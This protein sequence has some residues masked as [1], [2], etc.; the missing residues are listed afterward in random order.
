MRVSL[1]LLVLV[2]GLVQA[3]VYKT[4]TESGEVIYSDTPT[5]NAERMRLPE[6]PTYTPPPLPKSMASPAKQPVKKSLYNSMVISEPE[7]D[8]T[9]RD[10]QGLVQVSIEL[11]PPLMTQLGH[12][13]QYYL[14]DNPHGSPVENV[15]VG[16]SN[17]D[18]GTHTVSAY[19]IDQDEKPVMSS[20]AVTFHL[21]RE[22]INNPNNPN[23]PK[24]QPEP[25][26][27]PAVAPR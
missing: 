25:E 24:N 20:P 6:L 9:L 2:T 18:R 5:G 12:K 13:I 16:F 27:L 8:A 1:L 21:H 7:D 11:N 14:D 17:I 10:N 23:N 15:V 3:A 19:V 26:Q 22:S 4:V